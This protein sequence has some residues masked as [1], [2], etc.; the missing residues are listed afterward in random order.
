M[1]RCWTDFKLSGTFS[2]LDSISPSASKGEDPWWFFFSVLFYSFLPSTKHKIHRAVIISIKTNY[3]TKLAD[4]VALKCHWNEIFVSSII[5]PICSFK[6]A[7][8]HS[9]L[10]LCQI[11]TRS[12]VFSCRN[13]FLKQ[14]LSSPCDLV[15]SLVVLAQEA[16]STQLVDHK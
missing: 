1:F 5:Q 6:R 15:T 2:A 9:K 16:R 8:N 7:H 4:L 14:T 3:C 11:L 12:D 13:R 10:F